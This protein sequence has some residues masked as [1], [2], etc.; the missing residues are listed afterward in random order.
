MLY[1]RKNANHA[2]LENLREFYRNFWAI[3]DDFERFSRDFQQF[4]AELDQ[5]GAIWAN[6]LQLSTIEIL[7]LDHCNH[8]S[9]HN[10]THPMRCNRIKNP[11]RRTFGCR[12]ILQSKNHSGGMMI[13]FHIDIAPTLVVNLVQLGQENCI[14]IQLK[15]ILNHETIL[16]DKLQNDHVISYRRCKPAPC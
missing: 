11:K 9:Q 5:F 13:P 10:L 12:I 14:P 7:V 3:S 2:V 4:R 15:T 1:P 8:A 6:L 16:I